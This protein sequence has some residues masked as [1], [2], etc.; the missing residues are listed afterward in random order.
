MYLCDIICH[1][2]TEKISEVQIEQIQQ[3]GQIDQE[4]QINQID[5]TAQTDHANSK[6]LSVD[7]F[8]SSLKNLLQNNPVT[9]LLV[10]TNIICFIVLEIKGDTMD[11]TFMLN[12][13]AMNPVKMLY[14]GEWYRLITA[15]FMHLGIEHLFNNMLLLF[16]LGQMV[17]KAVKPTKF[18]SIY[19]LS[20]FFG[21]FIS[22]FWCMLNGRNN[23]VCGASGAIFGIVGAMIIIIILH[24]GR[25]EG[26]TITRMLVMAILTLY[27]GFATA[28]TD[29]AGHVGGLISGMILT[30]IIY[31]SSLIR[32]AHK[33]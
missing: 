12:H 16:F 10:M 8:L 19:M 11:G 5:H 23:I 18:L 7:T 26:I 33:P 13:G 22:F 15:M 28:G 6:D 2:D 24:K 30:L 17:E 3:T 20:G 9:V 21:G 31:G 1:M 14:D 32:K 27:F 29:N 25:Y 4:V